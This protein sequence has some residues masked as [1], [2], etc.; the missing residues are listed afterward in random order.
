VTVFRSNA[1]F[2]KRSVSSRI[3]CFD[4]SCLFAFYT[5]SPTC[6]VDVGNELFGLGDHFCH[7]ISGRSSEDH[8]PAPPKGI[9]GKRAQVRDLG[10]DRG[11]V[12]PVLAHGYAL[13]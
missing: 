8:S 3:A 7:S 6:G 12:A 2:T 11:W 10:L 13:G 4:I 1:S 5:E 9:N